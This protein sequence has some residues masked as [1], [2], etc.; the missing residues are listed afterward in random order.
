MTKFKRITASC[1]AALSVTGL[2]CI[3]ANASGYP[4][5]HNWSALGRYVIGAP[6]SVNSEPDIFTIRHGKGGAIATMS[7]ITHTTPGASGQTRIHC[8]NYTMPDIILKNY[9]SVPKEVQPSIGD[10]T[11]DIPVR[12]GIY[13]STNTAGDT[14]VSTG[15]IKKA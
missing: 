10:P 8:E 7:G 11:E 4:T 2:L 3:S 1:M 5:S 6:S 14:V 9:I 13:A 12:Y 15:L